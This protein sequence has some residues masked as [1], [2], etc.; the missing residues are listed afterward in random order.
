MK[1]I[2]LLAFVSMLISTALVWGFMRP[3]VGHTSESNSFYGDGK[4]VFAS[5]KTIWVP[6]NFTSIQE[7]INNASDGDTIFVRADTYYEHVTISKSVSLIGEDRATTIIDGG[8]KG[9]IV[10]VTADNVV[11]NGLTM[12]N[13]GGN[14]YWSF[15]AGI[16][17]HSS[18]NEITGNTLLNNNYGIILESYLK[19]SGGNTITG[20]IV[21]NNNYGISGGGRKNVISGNT[22]SDNPLNGIWFQGLWGNDSN[23]VAGNIVSNSQYGISLCSYI[24]LGGVTS[25]DLRHNIL[26]VS[27]E[28]PFPPLGNNT[29]SDNM[30]TSC[31]YGIDIVL[32]NGNT[33]ITGNNIT[34]NNVGL[35]II[36]D[37]DSSNNTIYHNN[38]I[39][40]QLQV[41]LFNS[42]DN[43]WDDG[44]PSGGN[45]WS[46][47]N[48]TDMNQDGIG[49]TPYEIDVDN[50]DNYPLM[51]MFSDFPVTH[52][53]ETY[54]VTTICNS[55]ISEFQFNDVTKT[56]SFNVTGPDYTL[57]FCRVTI[58]NIL[59]QDLWQE[60]YA[61]LVDGKEPIT[62]N[63]WTDGT[64]TYIYF[65]YLH[66]THKVEIIPEFPAWTSMLLTLILLA[67]AITIYKRRLLKIP[68]H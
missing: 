34:S 63:N 54:H 31:E 18:N 57:G 10:S 50:I 42:V 14:G 16:Y 25:S 58:P 32:F 66:S 12:R 28:L 65:T 3:T 4:F 37:V 1:K 64:Y 33:V 8:G 55:T 27:S 5:S 36:S 56:I 7:A 39:N 22:V 60:N 23:T 44:Y 43:I 15:V 62:M 47:Y 17:L 30:V 53:E 59:V 40:N 29:V 11:I 41:S 45:Y 51:G 6:D 35:S 21:Q 24:I 19:T 2:I 26:Q 67:V 13:S 38:F 52:Q 20:N 48:G 61:V 46:D 49:D 68:I 9:T